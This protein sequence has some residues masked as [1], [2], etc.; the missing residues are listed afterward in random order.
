MSH[1]ASVDDLTCRSH[2]TPTP[3][4]RASGCIDTHIEIHTGHLNVPIEAPNILDLNAPTHPF[5]LAKAGRSGPVEGQTVGHQ[6]NL[7][8]DVHPPNRFTPSS[9]N[10]ITN[11][12]MRFPKKKP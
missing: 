12:A 11:K 8:T 2:H 7:Q 3:D 9:V 5:A 10:K 4:S 1:G 6:Y